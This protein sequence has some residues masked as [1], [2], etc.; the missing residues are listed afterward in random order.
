MHGTTFSEVPGVFGER[1]E[2]AL[3]ANSGTMINGMLTIILDIGSNINTIGLKTAQT[4][5]Q[6]S[7]PHGHA[8]TRLNLAKRLYVSGV[9]HGAAI[10]DEPLH[11]KI[12]RN[13]TGDPAGTPA[14]LRLDTYSAHVA[15]GYGENLPAILAL[16][17]MPNTRTILIQEQGREKT[18]I[19]GAE[20]YKI[21]LGKDA[22]AL[23]LMKTPSGH[24]AL[25]AG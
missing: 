2:E 4:V 20:M 8:I 7:R 25:M 5:E 23:A 10:C 11:C 16:R 19:P 12:A 22:R 9:G 15:E 13:E 17:S 3:A 6:V 24:L 1:H 14:V 21:L 18:I